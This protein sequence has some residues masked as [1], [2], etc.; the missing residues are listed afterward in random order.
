MLT[1]QAPAPAPAT[2][3][4]IGRTHSK[5]LCTTVRD[6]VAPMVLGMMKTDELI[7][8]GHRAFRKMADDQTTRSADAL[9][10]DRIYLN[11]VASAMAHNLGVADKLLSDQKRFPKTA[12]TDDERIA[13]TLKAQ[14][15]TVADEQRK[16]LNVV[17]GALDADEQGRMQTEFP[18]GRNGILNAVGMEYRKGAISTPM[19]RVTAMGN[20]PTSFIGAS[21]L[22]MPVAG[23]MNL[24][25]RM[26]ATGNSAK[27]HTIY[28][29]L[30][31][32][33]ETRQTS[34]AKAEQRLTPTVVAISV[35][36]RDELAP[37]PSPSP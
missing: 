26:L 6:A 36:C 9:D 37:A 16:T 21:G 22:N 29:L 2:L 23:A 27:G 35:A 24:D 25:T 19:P 4:E 18:G 13:Q 30:S 5:G 34:I 1:A 33:V 28:D 7:G 11:K 32:F 17:N 31:T 12:A 20:D 3:P 15:M 8:A 10:L 14:L